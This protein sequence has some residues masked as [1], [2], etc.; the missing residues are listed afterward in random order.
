MKEYYFYVFKNED[1]LL[2]KGHTSDLG[3]RLIEHNQEGNSYTKLRGPW[4]L[5]Y[6]EKLNTRSEAMK[7]ES[8]YKT[9]KGRDALNRRIG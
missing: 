1:G 8:Y 7:R 2:Y 5:V 9:G 4:E 3:R 6:K